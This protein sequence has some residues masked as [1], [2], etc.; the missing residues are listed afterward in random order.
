MSSRQFKHWLNTSVP[1]RSEAANQLFARAV[2]NGRTMAEQFQ[3]ELSADRPLAFT[4]PGHAFSVAMTASSYLISYRFLDESVWTGQSPLR[5][6]R[7]LVLVER[8][9]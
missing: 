8:R 7:S 3:H 2:D 5:T 1:H 4:V 6:H 9:P